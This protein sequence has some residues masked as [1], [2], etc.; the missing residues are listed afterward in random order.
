MAKASKGEPAVAANGDS[1]KECHRT[2]ARCFRATPP[3]VTAR[4]PQ[5]REGEAPAEPKSNVSVRCCLFAG[6]GSPGIPAR[7]PFGRT[8][9]QRGSHSPVAEPYH[10]LILT[11][12]RKAVAS[13]PSW[14]SV[15]PR[16]FALG[17]RGSCRAEIKC[18][19]SVLVVRRQR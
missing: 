6:N 2:G 7:P 3:L 19:R 16:K 10:G 13:S 8:K 12:Q 9:Q 1:L 15:V 4:L 17:G 18:E 11:Q 5:T 14:C